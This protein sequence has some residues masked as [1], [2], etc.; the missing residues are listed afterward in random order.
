MKYL[1]LGA[2]GQLG[3]EFLKMLENT[4]NTVYGFDREELDITSEQVVTEA[5]ERIRPAL[6]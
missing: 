1:V 5:F 3:L 6:L 2:K 4:T